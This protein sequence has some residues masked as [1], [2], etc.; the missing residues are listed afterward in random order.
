MNKEE[1]IQ[2]IKSN[3][4]FNVLDE[5]S[6]DFLA[7]NAKYIEYNKDDFIFSYRDKAD[8]FYLIIKGKVNLQ[9]FSHK[10]GEIVLE[11]K[12]EGEILGWS[13][14][15]EPYMWKFD[16]FSLTD[17]KLLVFNAEKIKSKMDKNNKFGYAVQS[18]FMNILID[19]IQAS[20]IRLLK[21]LGDN[22]YISE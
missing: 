9:F 22:I 17:S 2:L 14:L 10:K 3:S 19:R 18:I 1:I 11:E 5:K 15:K 13:W 20:R 4:Y 12:K 8:S 7:D 16:G 21:E 6:I